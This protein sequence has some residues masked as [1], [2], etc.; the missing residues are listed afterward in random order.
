MES[1]NGETKEPSKFR[2]LANQSTGK[3]RNPFSKFF[4]AIATE[5]KNPKKEAPIPMAT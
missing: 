4:T 1:L 2:G 3:A 5:T